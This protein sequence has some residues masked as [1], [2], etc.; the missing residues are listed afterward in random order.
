MRAED[1]AVDVRLVDH[2]DR[3]VREEVAPRPV[4]GQDPHVEHVGVGEDEVRPP[5]DRRALLALG[6]AVVDRRAHLLVQPEGVQRAG[7]VLGERLGRVEVERPGA[8]VGAEDVER[9]QVEAQRLAAR[10]AGRDDRRRL[11]GASPAPPPGGCRAA[12]MP[13]F[14][15]ARADRRV[16]VGGDR[17][18]RARRARPR[19]PR[20]RGARRRDR[21]RAGRSRARS[22]GWSPLRPI[23][24]ALSS[25][26]PRARAALPRQLRQPRRRSG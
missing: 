15:S 5:A 11:P 2:D 22:G 10:G 19:R 26:W 4:V 20:A 7:L 6:V 9:R 25:G 24:E 14:A 16:Q 18:R 23:V 1:A 3:E 17:R 8:R 13:A 12:S 21:R